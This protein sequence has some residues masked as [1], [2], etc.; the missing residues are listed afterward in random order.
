M[1]SSESV[2]S[3]TT[4]GARLWKV[5]RTAAEPVRT[6]TQEQC[7]TLRFLGRRAGAGIAA[8]GTDALHRARQASARPAGIRDVQVPPTAS[9][10]VRGCVRPTV[11][12]GCQERNLAALPPTTAAVPMCLSHE[13]R[14]SETAWHQHQLVEK[15]EKKVGSE[16]WERH[17]R[18]AVSARGPSGALARHQINGRDTRTG[19]RTNNRRPRLRAVG[20]HCTHRQGRRSIGRRMPAMPAGQLAQ[21]YLTTGWLAAKWWKGCSADTRRECGA[22]RWHAWAACVWLAVGGWQSATC[23]MPRATP[24]A[25][26]P[27]CTNNLPM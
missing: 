23:H 3:L 24:A 16:G 21:R 14:C 8:I 26:L 4:A 25:A 7:P 6:R 22:Q 27:P 13:P 12:A 20:P 17:S 11:S 1:P 15:W 19:K 18:E 9:R 5:T 2:N 10:L